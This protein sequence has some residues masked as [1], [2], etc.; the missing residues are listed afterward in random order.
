MATLS[1]E[2]YLASIK[3]IVGDNDSD[4]AMSFIENMTDTFDDMNTRLED[5]TD[6]KQ[7]Y[8]EN[9]AEWRNK[10]K[11]RFFSS[12][13]EDDDIINEPSTPLT[14]EDLFKEEG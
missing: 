5:K 2:D 14:F 12:N 10:Y 1:R 11:Q 13:E 4:E 9:D 8:E 3:Q 7:K 6:W